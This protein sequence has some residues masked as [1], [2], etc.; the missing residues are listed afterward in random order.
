MHGLVAGRACRL[1][2]DTAFFSPAEAMRRLE[3]ALSSPT[4]SAPEGLMPAAFWLEG[5]LKGSGL[6]LVH[7]QTLWQV[8]D[9]WLTDLNPAQFLGILPLLRRTFAT[10]NQSLR[11]QLSERV[12][13]GASHSSTGASPQVGFDSKQAEAVLPVVA[14]LLGLE[15]Q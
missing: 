7:D 9:Q 13:L 14:R 8:L 2:L 4:L 1:L 11:Q 10:F 3:R 15:A 5:F 6:L 12:R